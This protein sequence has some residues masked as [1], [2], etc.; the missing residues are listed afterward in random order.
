MVRYRSRRDFLRF[1]SAITRDGIAI[2]K[3][4]A[5]RRLRSSR[6]PLLSLIFVRGAVG[7]LLAAIGLVL[8]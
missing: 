5:S 1:A 2:H 8:A 6:Q 3:W 7:V 4:A